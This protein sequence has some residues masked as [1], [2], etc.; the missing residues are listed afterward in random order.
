MTA[1][2]SKKAEKEC[3]DQINAVVGLLGRRWANSCGKVKVPSSSVSLTATLTL[4]RGHLLSVL[5]STAPGSARSLGLMEEVE[6]GI[7]CDT[8][9][10]HRAPRCLAPHLEAVGGLWHKG[11]KQQS[12][13]V[14]CS[15]PAAPLLP[16]I[17]ME[18]G[19]ILGR[20]ANEGALNTDDRVQV[21]S[22]LQEAEKEEEGHS[23]QYRIFPIRQEPLCN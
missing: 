5:Y 18:T 3:L 21:Q 4:F 17:Q 1:W 10:W 8:P 12:T 6:Q 13:G 20:T 16:I 19:I 11:A 2:N 22:K 15:V 14:P 9:D 7:L 23:K